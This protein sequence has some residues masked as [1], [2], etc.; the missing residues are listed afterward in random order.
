MAGCHCLMHTSLSCPR[1]LTRPAR[2]EQDGGSWTELCGHQSRLTLWG[3][4]QTKWL[5]W[6]CM[7][8]RS[9]CEQA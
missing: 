6:L 7:G 1:K 8:Q 3:M 9:L 4:E 2:T 5:N